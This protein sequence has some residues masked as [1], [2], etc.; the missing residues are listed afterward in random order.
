[1]E[2]DQYVIRNEM[3]QICFSPVLYRGLIRTR[4]HTYTYTQCIKAGLP[5]VLRGII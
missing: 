3:R 4:T 1:M 2:L 5:W